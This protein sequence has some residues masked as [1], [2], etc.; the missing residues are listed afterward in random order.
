MRCV[1]A[2]CNNRVTE[3]EKIEFGQSES[4]NS[5]DNISK[6]SYMHDFI[7]FPGCIIVRRGLCVLSLWR[8]TVLLAL[9]IWLRNNAALF[10]VISTIAVSVHVQPVDGCF[11]NQLVHYGPVI[12][13]FKNYLI[14]WKVGI[15]DQ[16]VD[17]CV[18]RIRSDFKDPF[19]YATHY[20][21][22][23]LNRASKQEQQTRKGKKKHEKKKMRGNT[24]EHGNKA[25]K[26]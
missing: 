13:L 17:D 2:H 15:D 12:R 23:S 22:V 14:N 19:P 21:P 26:R 18:A 3:K 1:W 11:M 9:H 4:P 7:P 24:W 10:R 25:S 16:V 20:Q 6:N 8:K 5:I